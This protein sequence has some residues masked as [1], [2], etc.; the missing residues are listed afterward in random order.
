MLLNSI[1]RT[2]ILDMCLQHIFEKIRASLFRKQFP[3]IYI[4]Q[5]FSR[6]EWHFKSTKIN[7]EQLAIYYNCIVT[8]IHLNNEYITF[9]Y[10]AK[11]IKGEYLQENG[12]TLW[13][14][15]EYTKFIT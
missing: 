5:Q 3:T 12:R 1:T 11:Y 7:C 9:S 13:C 2:I 10:N 15:D 8:R 14:V 4:G 6:I